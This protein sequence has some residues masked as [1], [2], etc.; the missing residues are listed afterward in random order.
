METDNSEII[1]FILDESFQ[2]FVINKTP[3]DTKYWESWIGEHPN[4]VE[5]FEESRN[6]ISFIV[7]RKVL[8]KNKVISDEVYK[9]LLL[10]IEAETQKPLQ[11][12]ERKHISYFWYAAS[13]ILIV[14][15][16]FLFT[17]NSNI[18]TSFTSQ[19]L[20][21]IVPKGQRSQLLLPD[22]TRVWLN[23]GTIFKY[24]S[25]FLKHGREV[26]LE[27]EAFFNVTHNNQPFIV[28]LKDNLFVKVF[29]TEFNVKSYAEDKIVETT[30]IKGMVHFL[31]KDEND[32]VI[33]EIKLEPKEMVTYEKAF[34][35]MTISKIVPYTT[36][37]TN[38]KSLATN[39]DRINKVEQVKETESLSESA[40]TTAWKDNTLV[41]Q[42]ETLEEISTKMERWFGIPLKIEDEELKKERFTGNFMNQ[43]S[44]YQVLDIINRSE[45]IQYTKQNKMIIITKKKHN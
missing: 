28:H 40:I 10:Q 6:I 33:N 24:P 18:R 14:G 39:P 25:S 30:L 17:Y 36:P 12:P 45:P 23:S 34:R 22:G 7:T 15:L 16:A 5:S 3:E 2:R 4:A 29:G 43:E 9:K 1:D 11:E 19:N 21:V 13:A 26:Y 27:G 20:E 44:V 32:Q 37:V 35:K 42:N 31:R 38:T 41:F 8:P